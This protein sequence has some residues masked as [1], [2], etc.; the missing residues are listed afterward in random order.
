MKGVAK[1]MPKTEVVRGVDAE[2]YNTATVDC[3]LLDLITVVDIMN[4]TA[5]KMMYKLVIFVPICFLLL[6]MK[7]FIWF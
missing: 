6:Y 5:D 2:L 7:L 3:I 1:V 4:T